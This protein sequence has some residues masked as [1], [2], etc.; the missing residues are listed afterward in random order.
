MI[1][2]ENE[3]WKKTKGMCQVGYKI[4]TT[5]GFHMNPHVLDNRGSVVLLY[6]EVGV[7]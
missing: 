1:K 5:V 2:E 7:L 3:A 6:T 4:R